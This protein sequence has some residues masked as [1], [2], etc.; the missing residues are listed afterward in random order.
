MLLIP[1][2]DLKDGHCVRLKQGDMDQATVFSE[3]PAQMAL[4]WLQ[5]GARRLH[6]AAELV[7]E[8]LKEE[9]EQQ[10]RHHGEG[11][12]LVTDAFQTR[13]VEVLGEAVCPILQPQTSQE[14]TPKCGPRTTP[15]VPARSRGQGNERVPNAARGMATRA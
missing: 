4:H 14:D 3:D 6:V 12:D 13:R 7:L 9:V 2:I 15:Q 1:A 11:E 5:R 8:E 10:V